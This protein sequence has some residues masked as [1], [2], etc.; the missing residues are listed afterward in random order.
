VDLSPLTDAVSARLAMDQLAARLH[1]EGIEGFRR[2]PPEPNTCCGR[3][4]NGCV[5]E[6]YFAAVDWWREDAL[7]LLVAHRRPGTNR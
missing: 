3:G 1:A 2:P 6:G 5:W 4:C 7:E